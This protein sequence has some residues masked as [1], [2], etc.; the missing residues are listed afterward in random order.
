MTTI[1]KFLSLKLVKTSNTTLPLQRLTQWIV[2]T[3]ELYFP[4]HSFNYRT[5]GSSLD[6]QHLLHTSPPFTCRFQPTHSS[7]SHDKKYFGE[8]ST[9]RTNSVVQHKDG[10]T[11]I[12]PYSAISGTR[13]SGLVNST[14]NTVS[15]YADVHTQRLVESSLINK[16]P[17]YTLDSVFSPLDNLLAF[18][19]L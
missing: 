7:S 1:L 15:L 6:S 4:L 3:K 5:T 9:Y 8:T 2:L 13:S 17:N 11:P 14:A 16:M 18:H 10:D 12:I 19:I